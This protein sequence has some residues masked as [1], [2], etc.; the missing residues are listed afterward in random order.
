LSSSLLIAIRIAR[1]TVTSV[2][3]GCPSPCG[4][5]APSGSWYAEPVFIPISENEGIEPIIVSMF[6]VFSRLLK[7]FG[8]VK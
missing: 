4:S 2:S 3:A 8:E 1:R 7:M 5:N 6:S